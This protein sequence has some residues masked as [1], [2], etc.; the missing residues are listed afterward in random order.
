LAAGTAR[1]VLSIAVRARSEEELEEVAER[2]RDAGSESL[3]IQLCVDAGIL[4]QAS[5]WDLLDPVHDA[6]AR[7]ASIRAV[8]VDLKPELIEK[9]AVV[10]SETAGRV[11]IISLPGLRGLEVLEDWLQVF[12]SY[13]AK[14]LLEPRSARETRQLYKKLKEL[15]GGV[16]GLSQVQENFPS[17]EHFLRVLTPYLQITRNVQVSNY[18][19]EGPARVLTPG[20]YNNPLLLRT[21]VSRGYSGQLTIGYERAP[22]SISFLLEEHKAVDSFLKSLEE[23]F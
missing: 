1:L 3:W 9:L 13:Q 17:T 21:L 18:G 22:T 2:I 23:K 19:E 16:L 20:I 12:A 7:V 5:L 10:A 6:G 14:L 4:Q 11:A 15:I 8:D